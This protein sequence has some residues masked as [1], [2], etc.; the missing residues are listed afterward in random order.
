MREYLLTLVSV[1]IFSAVVGMLDGENRAKKY[2]R[3][4]GALCVISAIISPLVSLLPDD[5]LDRNGWWERVEDGEKDYDEIYYQAIVSYEIEY[6]E[7]VL[8]QNIKN[9]FSLPD[10]GLDVRIKTVSENGIYK[11]DEVWVTLRASAVLADPKKLSAW[12]LN[13]TGAT[14]VIVY[15]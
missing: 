3:F 11:V 15:E 1:V 14:P 13:A 6:A 4:L 9:A 5:G 8:K 12:V 2:I 10:N 7:N